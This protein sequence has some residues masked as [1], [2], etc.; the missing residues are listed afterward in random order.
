MSIESSK[1]LEQNKE[2]VFQSWLVE[3]KG[4]FWLNPDAMSE[5]VYDT[6]GVYCTL[7][8]YKHWNVH[9]DGQEEKAVEKMK[10]S[11]ENFE[12]LTGFNI[13]DF[14]NYQDEQNQKLKADKK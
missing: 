2:A 14:I 6:I 5:G 4:R 10:K 12:K 1:N 7:Q 11:V 9:R 8:T 13:Q 3:S